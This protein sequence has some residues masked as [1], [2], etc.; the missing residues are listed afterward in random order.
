MGTLLRK[1]GFTVCA[2]MVLER[3]SSAG[4]GGGIYAIVRCVE[5]KWTDISHPEGEG[6]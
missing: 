6:E 2:E 4:G 5:W 1:R 3:L